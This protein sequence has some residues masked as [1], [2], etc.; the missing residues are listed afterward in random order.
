M[1]DS[2]SMGGFAKMFYGFGYNVLLPDA[3][4]HGRSAGK[5]IWLGRKKKTF[6]IG[7]T[8]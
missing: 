8:K 3:R 6:V 4:A 7:L 1:S 5:Y 2:D